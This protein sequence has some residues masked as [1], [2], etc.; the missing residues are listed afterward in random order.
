MAVMNE[1]EK[2]TEE[3]YLQVVRYRHKCRPGNTLAHRN[4]LL[5]SLVLVLTLLSFTRLCQGRPHGRPIF[6]KQLL[7]QGGSVLRLIC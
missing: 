1:F 7:A 4:I 3:L 6:F 5:T 2:Q